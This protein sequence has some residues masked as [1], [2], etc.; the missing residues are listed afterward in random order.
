[1]HTFL[2]MIDV[3]WG[4]T[5]HKVFRFFAFA[6]NLIVTG[7]LLLGGAAVMSAASSMPTVAALF[8]ILSA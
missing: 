2:E 4:P 1:M 5:A 3:R 6:T 8:L 7:I